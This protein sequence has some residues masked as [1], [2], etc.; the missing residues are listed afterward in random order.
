M[1]TVA[2]R[3]RFAP[4]PTGPLH[5]GSLVAA[6]A[7]FLEARRA[8]GEW[9]LRI[10][11]LDRE[12]EV[13]GAADEIL[14]TLESFGLRWDGPVWR[15]SERTDAYKDAF[16]SLARSNLIYPCGCSRREIA[17]SSVSGI[18]GPVYPGTCRGGLPAGRIARAWRLRVP[19]SELVFNDAWQGPIRRNVAL[20]YGDFVIRRA[21]G[22]F[23]Y[24]LAVVVDD[25][26][27]G[28]THV[29]R[30]ADLIEST[31]R[32]ILLQQLLGYPTPEYAHH[33]VATAASGEKLSKQSAAAPVD[34]RAPVAGLRHALGFL[35]Q[36]PPPEPDCGTI[37]DLWHWAL[38]HWDPA[39]IPQVRTIS[40]DRN[41]S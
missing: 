37:A 25:A 2:Y 12:R 38:D 21:D 4:S 5:F 30:G 19:S 17:D 26:A 3:G 39:G 31:P 15:Q 34:P 6:V 27:Q 13:R 29:V 16:A 11:D 7:S 40:V 23:A 9:L 8:G 28:I 41:E 22:Y 20:D 33:P 18:E 24:Q 1:S 14:R 36:L 10:E 35:G 32:Q